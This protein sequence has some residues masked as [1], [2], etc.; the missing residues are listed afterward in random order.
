MTTTVGPGRSA[1]KDPNSSL[2]AGTTKI[3][4]TAVI[5]KAAT[6]MEMG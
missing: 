2:K 5:K 4:I 1:P 3:M 6:K